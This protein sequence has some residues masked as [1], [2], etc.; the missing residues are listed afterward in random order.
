MAH[1]IATD[2]TNTKLTVEDLLATD[3]AKVKKA[4]AFL[5]GFSSTTEALVAMVAALRGMDIATQSTLAS[6]IEGI[7]EDCAEVEISEM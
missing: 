5:E 6:M 1:A 4:T 2:M 3:T 7:C